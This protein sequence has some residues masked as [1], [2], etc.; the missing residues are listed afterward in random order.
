M[1]FRLGRLRAPEWGLGLVSVAL[2]V[3]LFALHWYRG[4]TGWQC[5]TA[6]GPFTAV[7]AAL[8]IALWILQA[9]SWAPA[10]PV[11][12]TIVELSLGLVLVI[13]LVVRFAITP[14]QAGGWVGLALAVGLVLA[15]YLSLRVDGVDDADAPQSIE[16]LS[17]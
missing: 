10:L 17:P 3:V 8:G 9:V 1:S 2:L 5:L 16:T 11:S 4:L 6:L 12:L 15:A 13:W 14:P 7:V